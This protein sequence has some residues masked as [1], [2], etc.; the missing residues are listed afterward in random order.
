MTYFLILASSYFLLLLTF[1]QRNKQ[2][3]FLFPFQTSNR[4]FRSVSIGYLEGC[5][6]VFIKKTLAQICG[7]SNNSNRC[8]FLHTLCQ[9]LLSELYLLLVKQIFTENLSCTKHYFRHL[10]YICEWMQRTLLLWSLNFIGYQT[11]NEP[12]V[13]KVYY[14]CKC[15]K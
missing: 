4:Q 5:F 15:E 6:G 13:S 10:G 9:A 12:K 14:V 11:I 7:V 1:S 2:A 8:H 3:H